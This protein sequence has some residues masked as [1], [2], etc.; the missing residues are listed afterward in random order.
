MLTKYKLIFDPSDTANSDNMGAYVRAGDDGTLIGHVGDALKVDIGAV[1]DLDIRDLDAS[2]DNVAISDGTDTMA[3]N[4]DGSINAIVSATDLDIRDLNSASDSVAAV[5]SGT[6]TIDSITNDVNVTATQLD[7]DD[8]NATDD[9][10][11]AWLADGSGN[12]ISSTGGS[13][14]VSITD[15]VNVEVDLSHADDSVRLGDGTTLTNVTTN[16]ALYVSDSAR[17]SIQTSAAVVSDSAGELAA[18]PL[19]GRNEVT[20]QNVGNKPCALGPS[21]VTFATGIILERGDSATFKW[22]DAV[23]FYAICDSSESTNLRILEAA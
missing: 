17:A 1:T 20:I 14:H 11:S 19:S 10:V 16:N 7:V 13:L 5:Q 9:A 12:A 8:L 4:A 21:G 22:S 6:W 23:D 2:Q 3:V 18:T 15:G